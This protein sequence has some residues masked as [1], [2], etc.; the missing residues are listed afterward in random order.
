MKKSQFSERQYETAASIDLAADDASPFVPSQHAEKYLG[1]DAAS[2]PKNIHPIWNILSVNIPRRV[3]LIPDLWPTLPHL[4]HDELPGQYVSLF[5]QF[6]VPVFQN[7]PRAKYFKDFGGSYYQV[8]LPSAQ[9][10]TLQDLETRVGRNAVVRYAAPAFWSRSDFDIH[11]QNRQVL[12]QSA[13]TSPQ[14]A[15]KH[16]KWMFSTPNGKSIFNPQPEESEAESWPQVQN[17]LLELA[18]K[19]TY[20]SHVSRLAASIT[21]TDR[22]IE[23][24]SEQA[25]LDR[26]KRYS[27]RLNETDIRLL[28]DLSTIARA[29]DWADANWIVLFKPDNMQHF[30]LRDQFVSH[31]FWF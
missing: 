18:Q 5:L 26:I 30:S 25:W 20:R 12:H 29:A 23:Y 31:R 17:W 19:E 21:D 6:K 28:I 24:N 4:Y 27:R 13:F 3:R 15:K 8:K 14:S 22:A 2:S 7:H 11:D 9:R 1:F 10:K 16:S